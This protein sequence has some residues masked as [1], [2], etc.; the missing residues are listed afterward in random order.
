MIWSRATP[1]RD[2][3]ASPGASHLHPHLVDTATNQVTYVDQEEG[4][5][6]QYYYGLCVW[7]HANLG[8]DKVGR[9]C[10]YDI[11]E[12]LLHHDETVSGRNKDMNTKLGG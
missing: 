5:E 6:I 9:H 7:R 2:R 11:Y 8:V 12:Q 10:F 3:C 1:S 4:H